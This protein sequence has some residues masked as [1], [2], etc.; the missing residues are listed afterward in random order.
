MNVFKDK[1]LLEEAAAIK[2]INA[3]FVEKDW[4]AVQVLKKVREFSYPG[5]DIIF[6]GGTALSKAHGVIQRFSEDVD[7]RVQTN[8]LDGKS[9]SQQRKLL[10]D[11]KNALV[12]HLRT[13]FTIDDDKVMAWDGNH[14]FSIELDYPTLYAQ[15][16]VLRPH[17]LIEFKLSVLMLD[18]QVFSVSSFINELSQ[19]SP[20]VRDIGCTNSIEIAVDKFS[21]LLWRIPQREE[22]IKNG[23]ENPDD[24]NM[25]RHL[26]DLYFLYEAAVGHS[27]FRSLALRTIQEDDSRAK[28]ISGLSVKE[29]FGIVLDILKN[30]RKYPAEY[31][32]FVKGMSYAAGSLP[33]YRDAIAVFKQLYTYVLG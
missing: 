28:S 5:F 19:K 11:F 29:K 22:D 7:F 32:H 33:E 9:K 16:E 1:N 2:N 26:H 3:V 20:E 13:Q 30:D 15:S 31:D 27:D 21:A 23:V 14:F 12:T 17:L 18:A 4:Y 25:V 10:S 6:S 8:L 24:R